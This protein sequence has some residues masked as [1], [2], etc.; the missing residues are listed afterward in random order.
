MPGYVF[1]LFALGARAARR[2]ARSLGAVVIFTLVLYP[3]VYLL[4]RAAF[5]A[6][7]RT[8]VEAARGLGP[9]AAPGALAGGAAAGAAGDPRRR[10][11]GADGG[12]GRLRH[13]Q[14]AGRADVHRRDLQGLVQRARPRR[15]DA[16]R[17]AARVGHAHAA[18]ARAL[19]RGRARHAQ[20]AAAGEVVPPIRLRGLAA[21]AATGAPLLLVGVVVLAPLAQL[22]VWSVQSIADGLLAPEFAA[23]ARNSLLLAAMSAVLVPAVGVL[24]A[25]GV[26]ASRSRLAGGRRAHGYH[27]LRPARLGGGGGG[28]RAARLDRPPPRRAPGRCSESTWDCCSPAP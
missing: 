9:V 6:Q 27:R 21:A 26:R 24:L 13:G 11:A 23:A 25:Y 1:T 28:D 10:R 17:H 19:L 14:P 22:A 7:S 3:Y 20:H 16:A 12:A 8:L 18:G 4:A 5:L 15:G 2:S